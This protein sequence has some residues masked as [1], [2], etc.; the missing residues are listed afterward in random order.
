MICQLKLLKSVCRI[1]VLTVLSILVLSPFCIAENIRFFVPSYE[2]DDLNHLRQWEKTWAGK[3]VDRTNVDQVKDFLLPSQVKVLKDPG[4]MN[5]KEYWFEIVPYEKALYSKGQIA[6]TKKNAPVA[7]IEGDMLVDYRNM[8]GFIFPQPKSG[9]EVM[10][11]FDMQTRGDSRCEIPEGY[12]VEP[13]TGLIREQSRRRIEMFWSG[14][15][16]SGP[17]PNMAENPKDFRRTLFS[18]LLSPSDFVDNGILEIKYNDPSRE[19]DEW[20]W[21]SRFRRIRRISQAQRGDNIDGTELIRDD[22]D[23]WYDHVNRNKY[24]LIGRKELLLVR[25]QD[26]SR[27][28]WPDGTGIYNGLQRERINTFAVEAVYKKPHYTYSRQVF[29]IDPELWN[30]LIKQCWDEDGKL[31]RLNENFYMQRK[32][33]SGEYAYV[34]AGTLNWDVYGRHASFNLIKDVKDIGKNWPASTF[35]VHALQRL[36]Y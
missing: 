12:V 5:A 13:R 16:F 17:F 18:K 27:V 23:G 15:A 28:V 7:K 11:N 4:Y 36:A 22:T 31:W 19:D 33:V 3:R 2:S 24:R 9:I 25:H 1:I 20:F 14:R 29:Y 30:I 10:Y 35:T 8:A 26:M 34:P 6:M 21:M 32:T